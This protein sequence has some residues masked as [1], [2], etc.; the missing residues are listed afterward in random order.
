MRKI[1]WIALFVLGI[2]IA[3]TGV[4]LDHLLPAS[5][6]G[7][8]LPQILIVCAG[9]ALSVAAAL[10]RRGRFRRQVL[11]SLRRNIVAVLVVSLIT[12]LA[13][14]I[15]LTILG[16]PTY[17]P[18]E[19]PEEEF[20]V[21]SWTTCDEAGCRLNYEGNTAAC[22]AGEL[23]GRFCLVNRQG[24]PDS[25][26]FVLREE[27]QDRFRIVTLGDS[28]TQGFSADIGQSYVE[29][30]EATIQDAELWN[31]A[32]AG[33]GTVQDLQAYSE[34]APAF[35]P[36]LTILGFNMNDFDDNLHLNYSGVQ[37][38]DAEGNVYFPGYPK[39]DRWG[40]PIQLPQEL[41]L[42]YAVAGSAPPLSNLE[43]RLG[44]TR[45][46]TI[47]LRLLDRAG[48]T[49]SGGAYEQ[50]ERTRQYLAQLRDAA[51]ALN[52]GFLI[53]LVPQM[54]DIDN[55]GEEF[56][57]ANM[58]M[59]ELD[60]HYLNPIPLLTEE[61]YVPW[62]D[63]HWNN[64]GHQKIGV[65]ISDCVQRFIDTGSLAECDTINLP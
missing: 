28:F 2:G 22:A 17:F 40:R 44:L 37:L 18:R 25:D 15:A 58:F 55:P 9:L 20:Q 49:V 3:L 52:S 48:G 26:D 53:L 1:I 12:L 43:A 21:T 14:E 31:L 62:P 41:V 33:T 32:I 35:E 46:G 47:A 54:A 36:Q 7:F 5:S 42:R 39:S 13:L 30:L 38:R 60:I 24:Y 50:V 23:A 6:P 64:A 45:L 27:L 19:L 10:S 56:A 61:D 11:D 57:N 29:Y 16:M 4:G 8:N 51:L 65:L 34:F 63:G 59:E